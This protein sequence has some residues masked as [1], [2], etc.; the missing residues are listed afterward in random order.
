MRRALSL[1]RLKRMRRYFKCNYLLTCSDFS[2]GSKLLAI[3]VAVAVTVAVAEII[4][5]TSELK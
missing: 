4:K 1:A 5:Q 3:A 2:S